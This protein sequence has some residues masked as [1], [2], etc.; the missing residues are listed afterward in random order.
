[1][2]K[3]LLVS[4]LAKISNTRTDKSQFTRFH[5][6]RS[7]SKPMCINDDLPLNSIV[8][9]GS[10]IWWRH[11]RLPGQGLTRLMSTSFPSSDKLSSR[12][13]EALR[14]VHRCTLGYRRPHGFLYASGLQQQ[15][16]DEPH[17]NP[18]SR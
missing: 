17:R 3:Q 2:S 9:K 13:V 7:A 15:S 10:R 8:L 6:S 4:W 16:V 18:I 11:E 14:A 1:M 12:S 5:R